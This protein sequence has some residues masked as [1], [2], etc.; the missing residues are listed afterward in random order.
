MAI[1]RVS[2][3]RLAAA[4]HSAHEFHDAVARGRDA[5]DIPL[6]TSFGPHVLK[7][8]RVWTEEVEP[9]ILTGL[10]GDVPLDVEKREVG[11]AD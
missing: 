9:A 6:V 7:T 2:P 10:T 4:R 11:V 8:F 5:T 3:A 1:V